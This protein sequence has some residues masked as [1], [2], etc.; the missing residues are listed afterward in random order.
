M[1]FFTL[2]QILSSYDFKK[3]KRKRFFSKIA[4]NIYIS[5]AI[6]DTPILSAKQN[7]KIILL[8]EKLIDR[9]N[10][11]FNTIILNNFNV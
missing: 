2:H 8:S 10:L 1:K 11:I 4:T 7:S 3:K 9:I 6:L 5:Y